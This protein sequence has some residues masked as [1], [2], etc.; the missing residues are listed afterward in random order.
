MSSEHSQKS[1]NKESGQA[2]AG[3][4]TDKPSNQK[5]S[6]K[7]QGSRVS[8]VRKDTYKSEPTDSKA[9]SPDGDVAG[10]AEVSKQASTSR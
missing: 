10:L 9:E 5:H 1:Q 8:P 6:I 2:Q 7:K 3:N 4:S